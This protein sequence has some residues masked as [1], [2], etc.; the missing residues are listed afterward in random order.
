MPG[1]RSNALGEPSPHGMAT[2]AARPGP[3]RRIGCCR[4]DGS[5]GPNLMSGSCG[6]EVGI[7][8]SDCWTEFDVRLLLAEALQ[9]DSVGGL[10]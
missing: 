5:A 6:A 4:P 1:L 10:A 2:A 8:I 9:D 3:S 7:E